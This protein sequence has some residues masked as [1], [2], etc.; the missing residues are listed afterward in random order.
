[1]TITVEATQDGLGFD[2]EPTDAAVW[3]A[4]Q[5]GPEF[6]ARPG[7]THRPDD[8]EGGDVEGGDVEGGDVEGGEEDNADGGREITA[9]TR[10]ADV[11]S[12]VG[13]T[14]A[15]GTAAA[16]AVDD[17]TATLRRLR[18]SVVAAH[19][20]AMRTQAA[21]ADRALAAMAAI[22][23]PGGRIPAAV[24][25]RGRGG[26]GWGT[27]AVDR[28][29]CHDTGLPGHAGAS[30]PG[31]PPRPAPAIAPVE[32]TAPAELTVDVTVVARDAAAIDGWVSLPAVVRQAL[33]EV[34]RGSAHLAP[35]G[36]GHWVLT[37]AALVTSGPL[38]RVGDE[39]R[40]QA[41]TRIGAPGGFDPATAEVTLALRVTRGPDVLLEVLGGV[42]R[43]LARDG[44]SHG[45]LAGAAGFA[46]IEAP[47]NPPGFA[48][49]EPV[50]AAS[51]SRGARGWTEDAFKLPGRTTRTTLD[52]GDLDRLTR[53]DVAG[54][55]GA[56]YDQRGV[57]PSVRLAPGGPLAAVPE[58]AP[59]GGAAGRGQ[60]RASVSRLTGRV[61]H[62]GQPDPT[63]L[64]IAALTASWQA[65][66]VFAMAA[67]LHLVIADAHLD[68]ALPDERLELPDG[69]GRLSIE[70][71]APG[72]G[73]GPAVEA[74]LEL[75]LTVTDIDLVPRP[76]LRGDIELRDAHGPVA[77]IRGIALAVRE[78]PGTPVGPAH[79]GV[80]PAFLGR[81][82]ATGESALLG[83]LQ[84]F[85]AARGDL[86]IALG[87]EFASAAGR[88]VCR[89]PGGGLRLV[90]RV[91][92]VDGARGQLSGGAS[93]I[94]EYDSP[95]DSW[96]YTDSP[97]PTMPNIV[98]MET[99]LQS[100]LLLGYYL[101]ATLTDPA[102]DY[103]LRNLDG[104]ATVRREVDLAGRTIRQRSTLLSTTVLSGA[105]LQNFQYELF[106]VPVDG[107]GSHGSG[108]DGDDR[109]GEPFYVGES[110]FGFFTQRT[111]ANQNGLDQGAFV[112]TWLERT[113]P[114]Q[115]D[116]RTIDVAA[117]RAAN[118]PLCAQGAMALLDQITVVD[119]G[120]DFGRGYL[121][122]V[123]PTSPD[124]W[125]FARHFWL[126]PVMPGSLGVEAVI[127]ALQE[128]MVQEGLT[129]D[130]VE[131]VFVVPAGL[132]MSWR[133]RGQI[134]PDDG[135]MTLEVHIKDV[136]RDGA[137]ARVVADASVWKPGMRIYGLTDIAAEARG[138][139]AQ[140]W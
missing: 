4:M 49:L 138:R 84:M 6:E 107:S 75:V 97:S 127:Q 10:G 52:A 79:G 31:T 56:R 114:A 20:S 3:A 22:A 14:A 55:F 73:A 78:R 18:A 34:L 21:L 38:P 118:A 95:A 62:D 125:F 5:A 136:R 104:T 66:S 133:Y 135:E 45:G 26:P 77:T 12:G 68:V 29:A 106:L 69:L 139:G 50:G 83:E 137:R 71:H 88:T 87:P 81:V 46:G 120:G 57:N 23:P 116:R 100:A 15:V 76:W 35:R 41:T 121:H 117:R 32:I 47:G 132:P 9:A 110:L 140:S 101:G 60:L 17:A 85:H 70:I 54:V 19:A 130:L 2:G 61:E 8:V 24:G 129:D 112:P 16:P 119:G 134:R 39:L 82:G 25:D 51:G 89:L 128:W 98:H 122:A 111:L 115:A 42:F 7:G 113:N 74:G 63:H 1:M 93:M 96:Y 11:L 27:P 102:N 92:R 30:A 36:G 13:H 103:V 99:S 40:V 123:R 86:A 94:T 105:I 59:R 37:R 48:A 91:M 65:V 28:P 43:W 124:D 131:P 67:G 126:D 80:L 64:A 108:R 44:A 58:L 33:D 53:G 109:D 72:H 90:D